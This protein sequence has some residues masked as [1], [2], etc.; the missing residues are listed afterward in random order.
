MILQFCQLHTNPLSHNNQRPIKHCVRAKL[1]AF[2]KIHADGGA[3]RPL[4]GHFHLC[5]FYCYAY[6][7]SFILPCLR[8]VTTPRDIQL[9]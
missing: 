6:N 7:V 3:G 8:Y 4:E 2:A 5:Y 9:T 1:D